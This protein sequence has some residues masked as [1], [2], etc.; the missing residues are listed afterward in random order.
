[1]VKNI[2]GVD[3]IVEVFRM[4]NLVIK[5]QGLVLKAFFVPM[6]TEKQIDSSIEGGVEC[7]GEL[8]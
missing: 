8:S 7:G 1:M 2:D 6:L 4:L 3:G 5:V